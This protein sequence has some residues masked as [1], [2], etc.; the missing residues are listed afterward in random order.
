MPTYEY[1]DN[2]PKPKE[3]SPN[4]PEGDTRWQVDAFMVDWP[5]GGE[6]SKFARALERITLQ[7][8]KKWGKVDE[9]KIKGT[10]YSAWKSPLIKLG[11]ANKS[12]PVIVIKTT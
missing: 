5:V 11:N 6:E 2:K 9:I 12:N 4:H 10:K 8:L 3:W 7:A 1:S